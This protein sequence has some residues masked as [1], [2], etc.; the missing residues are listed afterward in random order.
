MA[1]GVLLLLRRPAPRFNDARGPLGSGSG[2][3]STARSSR[4]SPPRVAYRRPVIVEKRSMRSAVESQ[5]RSAGSGPKSMSA[6]SSAAAGLVVAR[7]PGAV[8]EFPLSW[9]ARV[10]APVTV[11]LEAVG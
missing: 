11:A 6:A 3:T 2:I 4:Y 1:P 10:V 5:V 9:A 7:V 8:A